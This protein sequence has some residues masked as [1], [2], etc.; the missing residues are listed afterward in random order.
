MLCSADLQLSARLSCVLIKQWFTAVHQAGHLFDPEGVLPGQG[1]LATGMQEDEALHKEVPPE[2][3]VSQLQ[4]QQL[5][6]AEVLHGQA[7]LAGI[8]CGVIYAPARHSGLNLAKLLEHSSDVAM[9]LQSQAVMSALHHSLCLCKRA[10][11]IE[12]S[13][14]LFQ[15]ERALSSMLI[16][17]LQAQY[18][19]QFCAICPCYAIAR[20]T[21]AAVDYLKPEIGL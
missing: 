12:H 14:G 20:W 1:P 7:L 8:S 18:Y 19:V 10:N 5:G 11:I 21:L 15:W 2:P 9:H 17:K 6:A 16:I 3:S 13:P 4:V